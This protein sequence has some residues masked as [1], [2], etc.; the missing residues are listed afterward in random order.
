MS[1]IPRRTLGLKH[2]LEGLAR[3][4]P[5]DDQATT[6]GDCF[7]R[8]GF[9]ITPNVDQVLRWT[10]RYFIPDMVIALMLRLAQK[11]KAKNALDPAG[12]DGLLL[13]AIIES[14]AAATGRAFA[15]DESELVF[16]Q[17]LA[18]SVGF[19]V[20]LGDAIEWLASTPEQ[21]DLIASCLPFSSQPMART[22]HVNGGQVDCRDEYGQIVMAAASLRL[23]DD[24]LGLFVVPQ[25]FLRR[26]DQRT[27]ARQLHALGLGLDAL[28][29]LPQTQGS[30][31]DIAHWSNIDS[32]VR[33]GSGHREVEREIPADKTWDHVKDSSRSS[34]QFWAPFQPVGGAIAVVRRMT[35]RREFFVG[36]IS[37]SV[38]RTEALFANYA[39]RSEG[40]DVALGR[41][42]S[43]ESFRG[44]EALLAR[45]REMALAKNL[46][47]EWRRTDLRDLITGITLVPTGDEHVEAPDSVYVPLI[48]EGPA[49]TLVSE[50]QIKHQNYAQLRVRSELID[51]TFLARFMSTP[52]GRLGRSQQLSGATIRKLTKGSI[53]S[54]AVYVPPLSTQRRIVGAA[55]RLDQISSDLLERRERL[56][57]DPKSLAEAEATLK[58]LTKQEESGF[59]DWLDRLPFPLASILWAYHTTSP[60]SKMRYGQLVQFFEATAE[61]H[62][63]ILLSAA[64]A[65][66]LLHAADFEADFATSI[67][68]AGLRTATF[69]TWNS[70]LGFVA[71]YLRTLLNGGETKRAV[72]VGALCTSDD[73]VLAMLTSS[74]LVNLLQK[75]NT[76]RNV[77]VGPTGIVSA[78]PAKERENALLELLSRLRV[79]YGTCWDRLDLI[80]PGASRFRQGVFY[81]T[82]KRVM[83]RSTPFE[84][85]PLEA[86]HQLEDN[87]LHLIAAGERRLLEL[88][89][90]VVV[91]ASPGAAENACYFYNRQLG[92]DLRYVSY[93]FEEEAERF[94][95]D[96]DMFTL[97]QELSSPP[98]P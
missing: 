60:D 18:S 15:R 44:L 3:W 57:N 80:L 32:S 66:G 22:F 67:R 28:F 40:A 64:R 24:G 54:V 65:G 25:W 48:G 36:E 41:L 85:R 98:R 52:L 43:I 88:L 95:H 31:A 45:E 16:A 58:Q 90:F 19:T 37:F 73:T 6:R 46:S 51:P 92:E 68:G 83:G 49:K 10:G 89:P 76:L 63:V 38:E 86:E 84:G 29:Y 30:S 69:G 21:F 42:V 5:S 81:Y 17:A 27:V 78:A 2:C 39:A 9:E 70:I 1:G 96:A 82:A 87:R 8:H 93:H 50:L 35:A 79:T 4:K 26:L 20:T 59:K 14:G 11:T 75:A 97:I 23:T 55:T 56:W 62:A 12:S 61:F 77:W 33:K 91:A 71:K 13:S 47:P 7:S 74:E 94:E 72:A 53:P 34:V